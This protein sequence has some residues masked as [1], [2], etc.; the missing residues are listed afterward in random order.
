MKRHSP[1]P[2]HSRK[3]KC[4]KESDGFHHIGTSDKPTD[5]ICRNEVPK[6]FKET[7]LMA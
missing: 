5:I 3:G 4:N 1:S 6:P 7:G 2:Q